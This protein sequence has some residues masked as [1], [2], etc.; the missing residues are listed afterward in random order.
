MTFCF[1]IASVRRAGFIFFRWGTLT[2]VHI[3]P[4]ICIS[5]R[6][7]LTE[8]FYLHFDKRILVVN[9]CVREMQ[10]AVETA[11]MYLMTSYDNAAK[12]V[13]A[14]VKET[15]ATSLWLIMI[16]YH[17]LERVM[18]PVERQYKSF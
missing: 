15:A 16:G 7:A 12:K 6:C 11:W 4:C 8:N 9:A 14:I 18:K 10:F 13:V 3:K 17:E 5:R 1:F 2:N